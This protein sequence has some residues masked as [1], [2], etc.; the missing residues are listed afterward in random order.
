MLDAIS[1]RSPSRC[2]RPLRGMSRKLLT[3]TF[4]PT[5]ALITRTDVAGNANGHRPHYQ[6]PRCSHNLLRRQ[7]VRQRPQRNGDPVSAAIVSKYSTNAAFTGRRLDL[8]YPAVSA[9]TGSEHHLPKADQVLPLTV[10]PVRTHTAPVTLNAPPMRVPPSGSL[11]ALIYPAESSRLRACRN[12][13]PP[14]ASR[15]RTNV[16]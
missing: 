8:L 16:G 12:V 14:T 3:T 4:A 5:P 7:V 11:P 13:G 6:T 2:R 10:Q 15:H 9:R 1:S